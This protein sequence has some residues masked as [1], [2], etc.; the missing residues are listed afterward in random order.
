GKRGKAKSPLRLIDEPSDE[1]V[2]V[3]EPA[4]DNE[5]ADLQRALELSLKEQ[6][7]RTQGPD[8]FVVLREP[9][10]EKFQPLPEVQGKGK[11]KVV[12]EQAAHDLLTLQTPKK[13]SPTE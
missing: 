12:K 5:E 8:R 9:D 10:S 6:G 11:E 2:P 1:G 13:K 3:E 7:E 4:H